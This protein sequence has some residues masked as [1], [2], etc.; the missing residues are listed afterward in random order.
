MLFNSFQFLLFLPI[1]FGLYWLCR[2]ARRLQNALVVVASYYFYGSWDWRFLFLIFLTTVFSYASGILMQRFRSRA[3]L[4]CGVNVALNLVILGFFK[5]FNFFADNLAI[6][7]E[8]IGYPLDW[9]TLDVLLPVGI[10]FYTFQTFAYS[11]SKA[12]LIG[13]YKN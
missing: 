1:V 11:N 3:A 5:Y 10:S 13:S 9:F 2:G 4:I 12:W 6:I 7:F 8:Q